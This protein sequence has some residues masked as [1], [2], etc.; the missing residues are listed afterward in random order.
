MAHTFKQFCICMLLL[1][2][3]LY[4][5]TP[6]LLNNPSNTPPLYFIE[7]K[8]QITDTEGKSL[9][10]V[11]YVVKNNHFNIYIYK[12]GLSY[13]FEQIVAESDI[14]DNVGNDIYQ[15]IMQLENAQR[16]TCRLDVKLLN[17]NKNAT[18]NAEDKA[19]YFENYFN[20][21]Y[22]SNAITQV[23][24]FQKICINNIYPGINWILYFK[25]N[26]LKY[27]FEVSAG[28]N[29]NCIQM[30]I[31]NAGSTQL[32]DNKSLKISTE[33]GDINDS[34]L[35]CY[36]KENN[37][38]VAAQFKLENNILSFS[39]ENY[40][41][42]NTLII[43]PEIS[44]ST[45]VGGEG[46]DASNAITM[47]AFENIYITGYTASGAGMAQAG[48]QMTY[49]GG[50]FDAY[51]A[52]Y[53]TL[54]NKLWCTYVGGKKSDY[55]TNICIDNTGNI[56]ITGLEFSN[57]FP[58]LNAFQGTY[59]GGY[60]AFLQK[61]D[62][63]GNRIWGTYYGGSGDDAGRGVAVDSDNNIILSGTTSSPNNIAS[64]GAYKIVNTGLND[65]FIAKFD[66]NGNRLWAT[67]YGGPNDD[68]CRSVC[69]NSSNDIII[70]GY[71]KSTS[72]IALAGYDMTQGGNNDVYITKFNSAGNLIW[73]TYYG[74][75]GDDNGNVIQCDDLGNIYI[76]LQTNSATG[77]NCTG[78]NTSINGAYDAVFAKFSGDGNLTWATY[79]GGTENDFG[80]AL[81]VKNNFVYAAGYTSSSSNISLNGFQNAKNGMADA[82]IAKFNYDG[83]LQWASYFGSNNDEYGRAILSKKL[84][85]IYF[86][87]KTFSPAG[88][89]Y[90][91]TQ[92]TF[93]GGVADGFIIKINECEFTTKYYADLDGDG[94]GGLTDSLQA[95]FP[96][97]GYVSNF[98]DCNDALF[99]VNPNRI[100]VCNS[101]DDNCNGLVDENILSTAITA[102]GPLNFCSGGNVVLQASTGTSY[103]WKKNEIDIV[104]ATFSSLTVTGPG[105]Y[106]VLISV[107]GGCS[108]ISESITV[109]IFN[110]PNPN[111][112][113]AG[114][115]NLCPAGYVKLKTGFTIGSVYEWYFNGSLISGATGN[116][117]YAYAIGNYYVKEINI[118]G[119]FKNSNVVTVINACKESSLQNNISFI[120]F[121]NPAKNNI[122]LQLQVESY[123]NENA[124]LKIINAMGQQVFETQIVITD[125]EVNQNL[126]IPELANGI[127]YLQIQTSN[128]ILTTSVQIQN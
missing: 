79:F 95:C 110:K 29:P 32:I 109:G 63:N 23:G 20:S 100:E 14:N 92:N 25:D 128:S 98:I 42:N 86:I 70:T 60:D 93:G 4:A 68:E 24:A 13:Q 121:P 51:L 44:W 45:Y 115:L 15:E 11:L 114:G 102:S 17:A 117:Y 101:L 37:S 41:T 77:F 85:T 72:G 125:G 119:C 46:E 19:A 107:A 10:E 50:G 18:V 84:S 57:N 54:G 48:I 94:F 122:S 78:Y 97:N 27:D 21:E 120:V 1:P 30:Q 108:V 113:T 62:S 123:L 99:T 116:V 6:G 67:Y 47:D 75:T 89:S 34:N 33:L 3:A 5:N 9:S 40:N 7:N 59:G 28:V 58:V 74:G 81:Y 31:L 76:G 71:T 118:N 12:D 83:I 111:I 36:E 127:Y 105:V 2:T 52:K 61:F 80:K 38:K 56:Y 106:N 88:I 53:D 104:G 39:T 82:Y 91:G 64:A 90:K 124:E 87:G 126:M 55:G 73:G 43:D 112:S 49:G 96:P 35:Y 66:S 65:A 8:G 26:T 16:K 103:Q 22:S 69:I